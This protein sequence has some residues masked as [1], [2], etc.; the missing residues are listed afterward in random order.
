MVIKLSA[1]ERLAPVLGLLGSVGV[2]GFLGLEALPLDPSALMGSGTNLLSIG[3]L[4][5]TPAD[6][7]SLLALVPQQ[8]G[9][10]ALLTGYL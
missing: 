2:G 3:N 1:A 6:L 7:L 9:T 5:V 10:D 8:A 4:P